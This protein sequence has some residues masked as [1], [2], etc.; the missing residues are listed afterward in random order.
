MKCKR[1]L[2]VSLTPCPVSRRPCKSFCLLF[3]SK[4]RCPPF[5]FSGIEGSHLLFPSAGAVAVVQILPPP[6]QVLPTSSATGSL[7][8]HGLPWLVFPFPALLPLCLSVSGSKSGY[9]FAFLFLF[10]FLHMPPDSRMVLAS[11]APVIITSQ[12]SHVPCIMCLSFPL[13][14]HTGFSFFSELYEVVM[15]GLCWWHME[16]SREEGGCW[17]AEIQPCM[18]KQPMVLEEHAGNLLFQWVSCGQG[19]VEDQR[20]A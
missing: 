16:F 10:F 15:C 7:C 19:A 17:D 4:T 6:G 9:S 5:S 2:C 12:A 11:A 18:E 14:H 3:H 20:G 8:L 1:A 13:L